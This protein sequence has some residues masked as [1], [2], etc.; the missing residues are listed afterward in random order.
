MAVFFIKELH[1]FPKTAKFSFEIIG[2]QFL[3]NFHQSIPIKND[4]AVFLKIID[5]GIL[6]SIIEINHIFKSPSMLV[7]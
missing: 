5:L 1:G 3:T 2:I 7:Y 4:I 6:S